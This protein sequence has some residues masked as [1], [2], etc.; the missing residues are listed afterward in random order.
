MESFRT[1]K[2][3]YQKR[4][5]GMFDK[6]P[7]EVSFNPFPMIDG[8]YYDFPISILPESSQHAT[9]PGGHVPI[10]MWMRK[11]QSQSLATN[12]PLKVRYEAGSMDTLLPGHFL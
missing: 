9:P 10:L 3:Y 4:N 1:I 11:V 12:Y 8:A 6:F 2:E 5:S 7:Q